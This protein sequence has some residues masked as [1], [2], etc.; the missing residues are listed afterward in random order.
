MNQIINRVARLERESATAR[1]AGLLVYEAPANIAEADA[2][3][4]LRR[5]VRTPP[6]LV[7]EL[8][9]FGR[10]IAGPRLVRLDRSA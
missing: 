9:R 10:T 3:D 4:W 2:A 8:R 6:A 1:N 7:I 5:E